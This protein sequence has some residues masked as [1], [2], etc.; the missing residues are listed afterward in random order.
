MVLE[1]DQNWDRRAGCET[2][3]A[4]ECKYTS[5]SKTQLES[6]P[7]Y[8]TR[9]ERMQYLNIII[10]SHCHQS[11]KKFWFFLSHEISYIRHEF[12][13]KF[14]IKGNVGHWHDH[15]NVFFFLRQFNNCFLE[16]K[17]T[18]FN[19][20]RMDL[21]QF[22]KERNKPNLRMRWL[23]SRGRFPTTSSAFLGTFLGTLK[24]AFTRKSAF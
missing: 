1:S 4:Q 23:I 24:S 5:S 14:H 3:Q 6:L 22:S 12:L 17:R 8:I 18:T 19:F 13:G 9:S 21:G 16:W 20:R 7:E 11:K 15:W 10:E 2:E